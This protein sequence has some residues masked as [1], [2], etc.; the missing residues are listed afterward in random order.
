[1]EFIPELSNTSQTSMHTAW[2]IWN[3]SQNFNNF[4]YFFY[5]F[6]CG[7]PNAVLCEILLSRGTLVEKHS[8]SL[9]FRFIF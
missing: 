2:N 9:P 3:F 6:V 5:T 7:T 8:N 1:M 4:M